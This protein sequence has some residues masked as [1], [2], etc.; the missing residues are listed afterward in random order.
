MTFVRIAAMSLMLVGFATSAAA[1]E[2][3]RIHS[4][5]DRDAV[6]LGSRVQLSLSVHHAPDTRVDWPDAPNLGAF[7][8]LEIV[9]VEPR[10]VDGHLV[11]EARYTVLAFELG[12]LELPSFEVVLGSVEGEPTAILKTDARTIS[13]NSVGLDES[14]EIRDI[15][16][17]LAL[18]RDPLGMGPRILLALGIALAIYILFR[19]YR[20]A[21]TPEADLRDEISSMPHHVAY[22]ALDRLEASGLLARG[23]IKQY[24]IAASGIIRAYIAARFGID[25]P[26]MASHETLN[27][28]DAIGLSLEERSGF[29]SLFLESDLVKFAKYAPDEAACR[30]LIP[31]ARSLVDGTRKDAG[32]DAGPQPRSAR[33]VET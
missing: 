27:G 22:Q 11:S 6:S 31:A 18:A 17:P 30:A 9:V 23:E 19:R 5:I 33:G 2:I 13:V 15:S 24:Y 26:E 8:S 21:R 4:N 16:G 25:A 20:S 14:G 28:L 3:P 10:R 7:E 12:E 29:E 1:M 32:L